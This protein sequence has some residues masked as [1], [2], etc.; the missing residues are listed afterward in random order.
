MPLHGR[1]RRRAEFA[2][3]EGVEGAEA[4]GELGGGQAAVVVEPAEKVRS[5]AFAFERVAFQARRDEV[6]V[7]VAPRGHARHDVIDA[8]VSRVGW[9]QAIKAAA[10]LARVDG[11]AQRRRLP[12]IHI[13]QADGRGGRSRFARFEKIAP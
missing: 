12:K 10:A 7:G 9:P 6:A 4:G 2:G 1:E 8:L 11:L 5:G 13:F 3:G